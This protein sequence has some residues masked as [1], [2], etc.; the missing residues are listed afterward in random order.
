MEIGSS[1]IPY[2]CFLK[3]VFT[4]SKRP[5]ERKVR[6]FRV[7]WSRLGGPGGFTKKGYSAKLSFN[8]VPRVFQWK[9]ER[10]DLRVALLGVQLHYQR[11]YGG[12]IS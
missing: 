8:L 7:V 1:R 5:Y 11:H 9:Q 12:W 2:R 6:L 3:T 4:V 10:F